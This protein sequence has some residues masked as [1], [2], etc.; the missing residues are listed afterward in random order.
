MSLF[1]SITSNLL[2]GSGGAHPGLA[3]E[4]LN[5][6][7]GGQGGG[8]A[9]L[10]QKFEGSGLGSIAQSWVSRGANLPVTPDQVTSVLGNPQIAQLAAR[11]GIAPEHV[12]AQLSQLLPHVVDTLTPNGSL[13]E[14]DKLQE[15]L[16]L[17]RQHLG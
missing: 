14:A 15:G 10:V 1:D 5:M 9:S 13:P 8:L 6:L 3:G 11:F 4:L 12:A 2:Q 7:G 16:S 17:L